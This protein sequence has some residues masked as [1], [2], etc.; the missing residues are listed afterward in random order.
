MI[1]Q[2]IEIFRQEVQ[3]SH[4]KP[5]LLALLS[6]VGEPIYIT[7]RFG[8]VQDLPGTESLLLVDLLAETQG[9]LKPIGHYDWS[10]YKGCATA[11]RKRND[12][13]DSVIPAHEDAVR[14]WTGEGVKVDDIKLFDW[15]FQN[16]SYGGI[17]KLGEMGLIRVE[18]DT[19]KP[20]YQ[21]YG[22]SQLMIATSVLGLLSKGIHTLTYASRTPFIKAAW[23]HFGWNQDDHSCNIKVVAEN[24]HM[25]TVLRRFVLGE[26]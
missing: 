2:Q 24:P 21:N 4:G 8:Y 14:K 26:N 13:L 20:T 5:I 1:A 19:M 6:R 7:T 18:T 16:F 25:Q 9:N 17:R 23:S 22:L 12:W 11:D 10:I 3:A 15:G